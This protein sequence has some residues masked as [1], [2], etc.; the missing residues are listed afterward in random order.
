MAVRP[1][2]LIGAGI[3]I[4]GLGLIGAGAGATFTAQVA[5]GTSISTGSTALSLN[6]ETGSGLRLG[7]DGQNVDSHFAPI[8]KD[9][10]LKNTGTLDLA[11]TYLSVAATGCD[12]GDGAPLAQ[13]LRVTLT[14]VTHSRQVYDGMLCS[15]ASNMS[16]QG[17]TRPPYAGVGG[18]LPD[19]PRAGA[20][21]LYRLVLQPS[22]AA[23]GLPLA[24]QKAQT[25]VN[26]VFT[27][28]DY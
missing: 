9:L 5:G 8:S 19:A 6:G 12:G 25:S 27:G 15:M 24:A 26:L 14:D 23:Q 3:A 21:L 18:Q 1:K 16:A 28:F 17:T 22:D 10:L 11:S 4:A 13:A 20:S 7:V 2:L